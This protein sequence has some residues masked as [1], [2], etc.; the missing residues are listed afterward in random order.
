MKHM[1]INLLVWKWIDKKIYIKWM[2]LLCFTF[3]DTA[4]LLCRQ[5]C[6]VIRIGSVLYKIKKCPSQ[7][8]NLVNFLPKNRLAQSNTLPILVHFKQKQDNKNI[9]Q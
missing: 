4:V 2:Y 7:F 6:F 3:V 8:P 9:L 5:T 1:Y